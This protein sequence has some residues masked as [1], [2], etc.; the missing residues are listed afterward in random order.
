ML[1]ATY[2]R[3]LLPYYECALVALLHSTSPRRT[4]SVFAPLCSTGAVDYTTA[5]SQ[6]IARA[7]TSDHVPLD[8]RRSLAHL[9]M[10][11]ASLRFPEFEP[12]CSL[13]DS[14][15]APVEDIN[16]LIYVFWIV[17]EAASTSSRQK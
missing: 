16:H 3:C 2:L 14:I 1:G 7:C 4:R 8:V 12:E 6:E 9:S 13:Y 11:C 10:P 5:H 15:L 17:D